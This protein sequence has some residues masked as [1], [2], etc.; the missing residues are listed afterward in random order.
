MAEDT[1]LIARLRAVMSVAYFTT[2][3]TLPEWS[4]IGL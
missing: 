4:K 1:V 3:Q 2:L